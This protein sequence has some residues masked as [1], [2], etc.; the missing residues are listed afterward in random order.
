M[1]TLFII[2]TVATVAIAAAVVFAPRAEVV[3]EIRIA[4]TPAQVWAVLADP[5]GYETWNP[6]LVRME[7]EV[8][9]GAR[10]TNTMRPGGGS[11]EMTFRPVLLKVVPG[12]ELRWLGRLFVPRIFD[13]EHYFLLDERDGGTRLVHGERFHSVGLWFIDVGRFRP[14]FEAMNAA[15]KA[16]VE[17]GD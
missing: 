7:G 4:A 13:G 9:E 3:T 10:L 2:A 15:L 14:D 11:G 1:N 16:R 8:A 17:Q 5:E 6:F 12:K